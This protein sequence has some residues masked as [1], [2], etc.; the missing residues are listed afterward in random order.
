MVME[1]EKS[2]ENATPAPQVLK[3]FISS[4]IHT[5]KDRFDELDIKFIADD[6]LWL[7]KDSDINEENQTPMMLTKLFNFIGET[8]FP[9]VKRT[10]PNKQD[11][12]ELLLNDLYSELF[13]K[14]SELTDSIDCVFTLDWCLKELI[15]K[16]D[17]IHEDEQ[18]KHGVFVLN[19]FIQAMSIQGLV[20]GSSEYK[21]TA[22]HYT[23]M[24]AK[25]HH[26]KDK[27]KETLVSLFQMLTDLSEIPESDQHSEICTLTK[28]ELEEHAHLVVHCF[29]VYSSTV[30]IFTQ[31]TL[32]SS[33]E[34]FTHEKRNILRFALKKV[35]YK[36]VFV[37]AA[38]R[39]KYEWSNDDSINL[40]ENALQKLC[41]LT[42]HYTIGSLLSGRAS[43]VDKSK[44]IDNSQPLFPDGLFGQILQKVSIEFSPKLWKKDPSL[45]HVL[46]WCLKH[47]SFPYLGTHIPKL[48]PP[49]LIM[50]D[51]YK[52]EN[53]VLGIGSIHYVIENT[54]PSDLKLHNHA[55]VIFDTFFKLLYSS[56][57]ATFEVLLPCMVRLLFILEPK[58]GKI[59][60]MDFNKWDKVIQQ[61]LTTMEL[62]SKLAVCKTLTKN[63]SAYIE[64]LGVNVIKHFKRFLQVLTSYLELS[65]DCL[66]ESRIHVLLSLKMLVFQAWPVIQEHLFVI[67]QSIIRLLVDISSKDSVN[68]FAKAKKTLQDSSYQILLQLRVCSEK[69]VH[70]Y[71]NEIL[72]APVD[73]EFESVKL[74]VRKVLDSDL[75]GVSFDKAG[76]YAHR[77]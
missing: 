17:Q 57:N 21:P 28:E 65:C 70:S 12:L 39:N 76:S 52:I 18:I 38:H 25:L 64:P 31:E 53:R 8:I 29:S 40:T 7:P 56:D 11:T 73:M 51:D 14:L 46:L 15:N 27:L 58:P 62:E 59:R 72:Q 44:I 66:E 30:D 47:M 34:S 19:L 67:I 26:N 43:Q 54:N 41:E 50:T 23:Q 2:K 75:E 36:I 37:A 16:A 63:L 48:I 35:A 55:D 20:T 77:S 69:L 74:V 60:Q 33:Q 42:N 49:L 5:V 45:K 13:A 22:R 1:Q 24:V 4:W 3:D 71:L 6:E 32:S 61:I 68:I 10:C 9:L